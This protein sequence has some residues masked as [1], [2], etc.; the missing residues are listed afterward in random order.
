MKKRIYNFI[1]LFTVL[2]FTFSCS[3]ILN[4]KVSYEK[5][6]TIK[7]TFRSQNENGQRS[8]GPELSEIMKA[9]KTW[10]L[11]VTSSDDGEK[12]NFEYTPSE[13]Q[14]E[15]YSLEFN[16]I[17]YKD[18]VAYSLSLKGCN[19]NGNEVVTS[20]KN[21]IKLSKVRNIAMYL[22]PSTASD[23]KAGTVSV[24]LTN[25][26]K[27]SDYLSNLIKAYNNLNE[28]DTF[29]QLVYE[30]VN[31]RELKIEFEKSLMPG[32]EISEEI[33]YT[34]E[35]IEA[36]GTI[37]KYTFT[38]A[39]TTNTGT[40][41]VTEPDETLSQFIGETNSFVK[42]LRISDTE[43]SDND[44]TSLTFLC[45]EDGAESDNPTE[46]WYECACYTFEYSVTPGTYEVKY[47]SQ[48]KDE[49]PT[50]L[51]GDTVINVYLG[52]TTSY[53]INVTGRNE[54]EDVIN[55][56]VSDS[57]MVSSDAS[58]NTIANPIS[59]SK[60]QEILSVENT[61]SG[62]NI[63]Y[64][65][66]VINFLT[67]LDLTTGTNPG[68][69]SADATGAQSPVFTYSNQSIIECTFNLHGHTI[70]IPEENNFNL[71][72]LGEQ[73]NFVI[74]NGYINC[75]ELNMPIVSS[76]E[77]AHLTLEDVIIKAPVTE[78]PCFDVANIELCGETK[79]NEK[80]NTSDSEVISANSFSLLKDSDCLINGVVNTCSAELKKTPD[81]S[82]TFDYKNFSEGLY[83]KV[84]DFIIVSDDFGNRAPVDEEKIKM[85]SHDGYVLNLDGTYLPEQTISWDAL[86]RDDPSKPATRIGLKYANEEYYSR[87]SRM[88]YATYWSYAMD[89]DGEIYIFYVNGE[90]NKP[91]IFKGNKNYSL[92]LD[93]ISS[94]GTTVSFENIMIR[95]GTNPFITYKEFSD[96]NYISKY[97]YT[98]YNIYFIDNEDSNTAELWPSGYEIEK[99]NNEYNLIYGYGSPYDLN[100]TVYAATYNEEDGT[101]TTYY[102]DGDITDDNKSPVLYQFTF[103]NENE[104][105][106]V[107]VMKGSK[108][109]MPQGVFG[110]GSLAYCYGEIS[111]L[112][113]VYNNN[114]KKVLCALL[115]DNYNLSQ[116]DNKLFNEVR[117][118]EQKTAV[119]SRG[120]LLLFDGI[121]IYKSHFEVIGDSSSAYNVTA[122]YTQTRNID[123]TNGFYGYSLSADLSHDDLQ[124]FIAPHKFVAVKPKELT[125]ADYGYVLVEPENS[126]GAKLDCMSGNAV[127][128][129]SGSNL[130][131]SSLDEYGFEDDSSEGEQSSLPYRGDLNASVYI[132][133]TGSGF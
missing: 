80:S 39:N 52:I 99:E 117:D 87:D 76:G 24:S 46:I 37:Y 62:D 2:F 53:T 130:S 15:V 38:P 51:K 32:D 48:E 9:V 33:E 73:K 131:F 102:A 75:T 94:S 98:I 21:S 71:I 118:V 68:L 44:Y 110:A 22:F 16:T 61:T 116:E 43:Y 95:S 112:Q 45:R 113:I 85:V 106:R 3:N 127:F 40:A 69:I 36:F 89:S 128:E 86:N 12:Q 41:T 10:K 19:E 100:F 119:T 6:R 97:K 18:N 7:I 34:D 88:K 132:K 8:V 54:G 101:Q 121:D 90:D 13:E 103:S 92:S 27:L 72:Y 111:D 30:E 5:T 126:N 84:K 55:L 122:F 23:L 42:F 70:T 114:G 17:K 65:S 77:F 50:Q 11:D 28:P 31:D 29:G 35:D 93:G 4:D 14:N 25:N 123:I 49:N 74:K 81:Y 79:I 20:K 64:S 47:Y 1:L 63:N 67:D 125:I 120:A 96:D 58:G 56:Y 82:I 83:D 129:L 26:Y 124:S 104:G 115:S 78:W 107:P 105:N 57:E 109:I 59:F 133:I 66:Y 108:T 91:Y 60:L